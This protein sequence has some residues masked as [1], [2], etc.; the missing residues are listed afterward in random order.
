MV[1]ACRNPEGFGALTLDPGLNV[2]LHVR[3]EDIPLTPYIYD[4]LDL[5]LDICRCASVGGFGAIGN[6]LEKRV[7]AGPRNQSLDL[8]LTGV[9]TL[10]N[11]GLF[12]ALDCC[13]T[14]V[15]W[16]AYPDNLRR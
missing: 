15:L 11:S 16:S 4:T 2:R 12:L 5:D 10:E 13:T 14:S 8:K 3:L 6:D 7:S 9:K 1:S